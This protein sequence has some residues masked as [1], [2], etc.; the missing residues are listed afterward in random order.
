MLADS[1]VS[2]V[3]PVVDL[4]MSNAQARCCDEDLASY[5][6]SLSWDGDAL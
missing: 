6:G 5:S 4:A 1:R 3:L 2:A